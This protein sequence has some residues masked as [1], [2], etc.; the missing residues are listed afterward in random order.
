MHAAQTNA[1]SLKPNLKTVF[2][3]LQAKPEKA[4]KAAVPAADNIAR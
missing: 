2:M 4:T 3:A 1:L